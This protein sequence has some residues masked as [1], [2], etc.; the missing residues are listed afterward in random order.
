MKSRVIDNPLTEDDTDFLIDTALTERVSL[1]KESNCYY[2]FTPYGD[3]LLNSWLKPYIPEEGEWKFEYINSSYN[4]L[5]HNDIIEGNNGGLGCIIPISWGGQAP[6]TI[7]LKHWDTKRL[8]YCGQDQCEYVDTKKKADFK[9]SD[10]EK[11]LVFNWQKD[12]MLVFDV[13][14]LHTSSRFENAWKNFILGFLV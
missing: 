12:K 2:R 13:T 4:I 10:I 14:Q 1:G 9:C 6:Q 5:Y 3:E 11:D 7:M 8:M